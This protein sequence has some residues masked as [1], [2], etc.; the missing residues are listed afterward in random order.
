MFSH[1]IKNFKDYIDEINGDINLMNDIDLD[2]YNIVIFDD[3]NINEHNKFIILKNRLLHLSHVDDDNLN[4]WD[5]MGVR[6]TYYCNKNKNLNYNF[7]CCTKNNLT[8]IF[9]IYNKNNNLV[10]QLGSTC[11]KRF[12]KKNKTILNQHKQYKKRLKLYRELKT[13]KEY[14]YFIKFL[15]DDKIIPDDKITRYKKEMK[16]IIEHRNNIQYLDDYYYKSE[17]GIIQD[18]CSDKINENRKK[19][20]IK[21]KNLRTKI[22]NTLKHKN[23]YKSCKKFKIWFSDKN[24]KYYV[25]NNYIDD[26]LADIKDIIKNINPS[27]YEGFVRYYGYTLLN[28]KY[29]SLSN[30]FINTKSKFFIENNNLNDAYKDAID[31]SKGKDP[32]RYENFISYYLKI[33]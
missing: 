24:N 1:E 26:A 5:V 3:S 10:F 12:F 33:K 28:Y 27:R 30:N 23:K 4:V 32:S 29:K 6:L 13:K 20:N 18:Y 7:C 11:I 14:E 9:F 19:I 2:K 31:I 15:L 8:D 22:I 17:I 16:D 21:Y 25:S